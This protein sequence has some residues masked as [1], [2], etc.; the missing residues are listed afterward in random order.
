MYGTAS[1]HE[2]LYQYSLVNAKNVLLAMIQTETPYFQGRA[3]ALASECAER[4]T[5]Y[6]DPDLARKYTQAPSLPS[7]PYVA[8]QE[9]RAMG[10]HIEQCA[11]IYVLGAGLYSFF[12]SYAQDT[13]PAHACQ[14]R[15]CNI[16][17][18]GS[19]E[20]VW[21]FHLAT[22]GSE[23]LVT[24]RGEDQLLEGP[25]REGFCSTLSLCAV[26]PAAAKGKDKIFL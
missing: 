20:E 24:L 14:R 17:E 18:D 7:Q 22:V 9:D 10:I 4:S 5:V 8:S 26:R 13:L 19:S 25:H 12:D 15:V 23:V 11:Q 3:F 1:E 2:L 21:L 6:P 16:D